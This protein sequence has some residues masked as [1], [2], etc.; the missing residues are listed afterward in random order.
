MTKDQFISHI[1]NEYNGIPEII[2]NNKDMMEIFVPIIQHDF[3]MYEQFPEIFASYQEKQL[4]CNITTI[5]YSNDLINP[6]EFDSW[7][8]FTTGKHEHYIFPGGHFQILEEPQ[9]VIQLINNLPV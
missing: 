9:R 3:I 7:S 6:E 1:Q 4:P 2:L 8:T 5:G